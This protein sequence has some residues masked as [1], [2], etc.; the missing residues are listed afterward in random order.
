MN[1]EINEFNENISEFTR[2]HQA[3]YLLALREGTPKRK[4][5]RSIGFDPKIVL[6]YRK[7]N[8]LFEEEC[9]EAEAEGDEEVLESIRDAAKRGEPWAGR[10]YGPKL[11]LSEKEPPKDA[12]INIFNGVAIEG[13][14]IERLQALQS[15]V[16]SRPQ[17]D[18]A[19]KIIDVSLDDVES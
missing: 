18:P 6:E 16:I 14:A 9:L 19:P 3:R 12:N 17:I 8:P 13:N 2:D 15:E 11:G 1:E 10:L 5:A 4:A 7:E